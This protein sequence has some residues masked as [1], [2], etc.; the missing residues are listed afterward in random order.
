M[1]LFT[2]TDCPI[3]NRYAPEVH[4]LHAKFAN[5]GVD[6]WLVYPDPDESA[7]AIRQHIEEYDYALRP[8]KDPEHTL[9]R[10][11]EARVTP[12]AAVFAG[13]GNMV[14]R[15]RIDDRYVDFGKA[16]AAATT[17][18]LEQALLATLDGRPVADPTT[19]AVGCY[20]PPLE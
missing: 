20:I 17:H 5:R 14:Y 11:T 4:R 16:R 9:V 10:L 7:E 2:R 18:D 13:V 12:E 1:F 3:S 19:E 8:L 15:G 6:F